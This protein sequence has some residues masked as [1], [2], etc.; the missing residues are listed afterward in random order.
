VS[1]TKVQKLN[2]HFPENETCHNKVEIRLCM[3]INYL[4]A[5]ARMDNYHVT[6]WQELGF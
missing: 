3:E 5:N 1:E 6:S 4:Y 2:M